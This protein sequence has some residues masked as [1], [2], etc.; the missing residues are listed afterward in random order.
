VQQQQLLQ[1]QP[2]QQLRSNM[3]PVIN[4]WS[5]LVTTANVV[6]SWS[7]QLLP[8]GAASMSVPW[9]YGSAVT[10]A[11][12]TFTRSVASAEYSFSGT[13]QVS[14]QQCCQPVQA[15]AVMVY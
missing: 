9:G 4:G 8:T 3:A 10:Q 7:H 6:F 1:A 14:P 15:A 5:S 11:R 13:L 2:Q 12:A